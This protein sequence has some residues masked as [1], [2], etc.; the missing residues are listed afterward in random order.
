MDDKNINNIA[1][2]QIAQKRQIE[3]IEGRIVCLNSD[4]N[5]LSQINDKNNDD[6][7]KLLSMA[8]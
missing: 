7:D 4:M 5:L 6:L 8:Q 1:K 2:T 3:D